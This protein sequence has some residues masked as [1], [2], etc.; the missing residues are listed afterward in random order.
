MDVCGRRAG[1]GVTRAIRGDGRRSLDDLDR[2]ASGVG[3]HVGDEEGAV[4]GWW[5]FGGEELA[6]LFEAEG[7]EDGDYVC[8]V[9][10]IE[11]EGLVQREGGSIVVDGNVI[12]VG[13]GRDDVLL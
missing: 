5:T 13:G 4:G 10:E 7:C 12:G 6:E 8:V 11:V 1:A 2:E 3:H 9:G